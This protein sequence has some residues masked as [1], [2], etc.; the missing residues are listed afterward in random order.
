MQWGQINRQNGGQC[1]QNTT[2]PF[3]NQRTWSLL[4]C[5]LFGKISDRLKDESGP[6]KFANFPSPMGKESSFTKRGEFWTRFQKWLEDSFSYLPNDGPIKQR[7]KCLV[8][9]V[10][11][12]VVGQHHMPPGS[13]SASTKNH[14]PIVPVI[15]WVSALMRL[16]LDM[17]CQHWWSTT[18][19]KIWNTALRDCSSVGWLEQFGPSVAS[20]TELNSK[21][22]EI[23]KKYILKMNKNLVKGE[24]DPS[25]TTY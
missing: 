15:K 10:R 8:I 20:T 25:I 2:K 3:I 17:A 24:A 5:I 23:T 14:W 1:K 6:G 4:D 21:N 9:K 16:T 7:Q 12:G 19:R 18:K 11:N 22:R 13:N